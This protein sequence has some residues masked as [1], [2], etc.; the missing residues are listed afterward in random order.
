MMVSTLM[1]GIG[2]AGRLATMGL[3]F[4]LAVGSYRLI[5]NPIRH[6]PRLARRPI[7]SLLMFVIVTAGGVGALRGW[8]SVVDRSLAT[9]SQQ[10]FARA[11]QQGDQQRM[12]CMVHHRNAEVKQCILGNPAAA[13]TLA[14]FGD[15]HALQWL[16]ALESVATANDWR[17]VTFIKASCSPA[18]IQ[19][20]DGL[21]G[22]RFYECEQ[23]RESA[24]GML[25]DLRPDMVIVSAK[26]WYLSGN[27]GALPVTAT[28]WRAGMQRTLSR[29]TAG[30]RAAI[31]VRDTPI[32]G[33][34]IPECLSRREWQPRIYAPSECS[35]ARDSALQAGIYALEKDVISAYPT[36]QM[37]DFTAAI[38]AQSTCQTEKDGLV[39]YCDDNHLSAGFAAHLAPEWQTLLAP[40]VPA[41]LAGGQTTP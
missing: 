29:L 2:I 31:Y 6:H 41:S 16:P 34:N 38:C 39:I 40:L 14:V 33:F 4:G 37:A 27:G 32:P 30:G 20:V 5:E 26:Q 3:A 28:A 17:V 9:Q 19:N 13:I 10:A 15:S 24:L 8:S 35:F 36:V 21:L 25:G 12:D 1:P 7:I 23:W 11:V 22:R 18:D